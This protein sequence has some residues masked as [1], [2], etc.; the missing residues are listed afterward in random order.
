MADALRPRLDRLQEL[1]KSLNAEADRISKVVQNVE[2]A[3]TDICHIGMAAYVLIESE[4][5]QA[6]YTRSTHLA[7]AR[8]GQRFRISV[9]DSADYAGGPGQ[10]QVTLWSNCSRDVKL[11]AFNKLPELLDKLIELMEGTIEQAKHNADMVES[12]L[13]PSKEKGTKL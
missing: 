5:D 13:P 12:F 9:I 3:L 11:V 4:D 6:G 7:Y 2:S 8:Y 1:S 10:E